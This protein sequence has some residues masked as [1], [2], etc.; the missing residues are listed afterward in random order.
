MYIFYYV[1]QEAKCAYG[2]A[3]MAVFW[4]SEALP[5]AVTALLPVIVFPVFGV[6]KAGDVAS[7]YIKV[8]VVYVIPVLLKRGKVN[9]TNIYNKHTQK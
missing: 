3:V 9:L 4:I 2:L 8:S 7:N 6:M 1:L 5:L